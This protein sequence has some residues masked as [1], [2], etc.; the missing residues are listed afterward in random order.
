MSQCT[1]IYMMKDSFES[2]HLQNAKLSNEL[3]MVLAIELEEICA[4][5]GPSSNEQLGPST[6]VDFALCEAKNIAVN[7][8]G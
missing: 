5:K 7:E 3:N 8:L 4:Q 6:F 1:K 2:M